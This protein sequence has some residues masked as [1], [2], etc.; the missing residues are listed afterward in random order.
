VSVIDMSLRRAMDDHLA[1]WGIAW[2][3]LDLDELAT[4][5]VGVERLSTISEYPRV[6]LDFSLL[7]PT[8]V[9]YADV[10]RS[11]TSFAYPTLKQIRFVSSFEGK[12]V[13]QRQRSLTFRVVI[14]RDD[15]TLADEDTRTFRNTFEAHVRKCGYEI[16]N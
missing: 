7:V 6:E 9:S 10:T 13:G 1:A 15:R 14:G 12:S 11:L 2:A 16:R 8:E 4:L 5:Q 3:E